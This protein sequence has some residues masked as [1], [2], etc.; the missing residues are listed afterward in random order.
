MEIRRIWAMPNKNTF[1]IPPIASIIRQYAHGKSI[2]PFANVNKFALITNDIDPDYQTDHHLDALDFLRLFN[3][4]EIDCVLYDPPYCYDEATE[5]LTSDGWKFFKELTNDDFVATLNVNTNL[6]EYQKP[7]E[8][9]KEKYSGDMISFESQSVSLLVTPKHKMWTKHSYYKEYSFE[10]AIDVVDK[11]TWFKKACEYIGEEHEYFTLP[12]V[13]LNKPN[14]Y[15]EVYKFNK[16]IKM[17]TWLKFL[18]LY[19][20]DGHCKT[21]GM[22]QGKRKGIRQDYCVCL[23][24]KKEH[25][26]PVFEEVLDELEY[27]YHRDD[28]HYKIYDKQLWT[29]LN[30]YG[31]S[32]EKYLEKNIKKLSQR[33]L[34]ILLKY[35]MIGDGTNIRYPKFNK[36]TKKWYHY[37][38]NSYYTNSVKLM[39]DVSE[40]CIKCGYGITVTLKK[41]LGY[42][43]VYNIHM[44]GSKDFKIKKEN[45]NIIN[46][47]EGYVYCVSVPNKTVLVK[48]NGRIVWSGNSPRQV[49]EVYTRMGRTVN[50]ETTQARFWANLKREISRIAKIDSIVISCGWN[51]GGMGK[52][53]G[54]ELIEV[55]LVPHGGQH[56]DTI[57][58]VEKKVQKRYISNTSLI[59]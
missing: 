15:G 39:N 44:L 47:F 38:T 35:L 49:S 16:L 23:T 2:D 43:D 13:L 7:F 24:Q 21:V 32:H 27:S 31:H 11:N 19:L 22:R 33:Q 57:V 59:D 55:L 56:N 17:D 52:K 28:I 30:K 42:K 46:D 36:Q 29:Y 26:L 51:S 50:M 48:R 53:Y 14:R 5:V 37:T 9:I 8:I 18:G 6:L 25:N 58:T 20:S 40:I 34:K 4:E 12:E 3:D 1:V 41:K 10:D 54:F 45:I